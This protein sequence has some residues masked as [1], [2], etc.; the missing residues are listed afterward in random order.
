MR[1]TTTI[2]M[3]LFLL[4]GCG[5][6][7]GGSSFK[8]EPLTDSVYVMIGSP[9]ERPDAWVAAARKKCRDTGKPVCRVM[10]WLDENYTRIATPVLQREGLNEAFDYSLDRHHSVERSYFNCAVFPQEKSDNC[11]PRGTESSFEGMYDR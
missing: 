7:H 4:S 11:M 2:A 5:R 8:F 3:L 6:P 9:E 1:P 10:G